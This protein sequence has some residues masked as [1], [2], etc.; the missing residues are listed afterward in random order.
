MP[1]EG[2]HVVAVA[3]ELEKQ[4]QLDGAIA[5][6]EGFLA[7]NSVPRVHARLGRLYYLKKQYNQAIEQFS[8]A[9]KAKPD[10]PTTLFF[11]GQALSMLGKLESAIRDFDA[12]LRLQPT[13]ADAFREIGYIREFQKR[14]LEAREAFERARTLDPAMSEE[15][16]DEIAD[17]D[18]RL[19]ERG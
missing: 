13:A 8:I 16:D 4:G 17:L 1:N 5:A 3:D 15:L 10:A 11:R 18:S 6:L 7:S 9:L 19:R 12:C 2:Q 14:Y